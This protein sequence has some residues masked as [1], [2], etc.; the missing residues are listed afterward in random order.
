VPPSAGQVDGRLLLLPLQ[1]WSAVLQDD[2][3]LRVLGAPPQGLPGPGEQLRAATA[4]ACPS[5]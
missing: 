5:A 4:G 2:G 3:S 1:G